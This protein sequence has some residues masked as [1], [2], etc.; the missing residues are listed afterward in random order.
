AGTR[1]CS[2]KPAEPR[3]CRPRR[4]PQPQYQRLITLLSERR[5]DQLD[6]V[7]A[8]P[9]G[10]AGNGRDLAALG[11]DQQSS[12]HSK[13]APDCLEVLESARAR[14]GEIGE[15]LDTNLLEPGLRLVRVARVDIDRNHFE[16]GAAE[17]LLE[18]IKRRHFLA[19]RYAPGGP[20][21]E[22]D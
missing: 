7:V 11:I 9:F 22:Q 6:G 13:R 20:E 17:A 21:V 12:R 14:I 16:S 15:L 2:E 4:G 8:C 19:A 3:K 10:R 1:R 18:R 5:F